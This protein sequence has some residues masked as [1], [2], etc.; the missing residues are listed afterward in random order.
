[1]MID[2]RECL[3]LESVDREVINKTLTISFWITILS[4]II[5]FG[6]FLWFPSLKIIISLFIVGIICPIILMKDIID[7]LTKI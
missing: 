5:E 1:M 3:C 4:L 7:S 2:D 6:L